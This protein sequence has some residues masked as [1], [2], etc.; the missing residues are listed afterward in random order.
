MEKVI[1]GQFQITKF[2]TDGDHSEIVQPE[3][4]A[5][6]TAVLKKYVDQYGSVSEAIKH[7]DEFAD[8]EW[9]V[10]TTNENGIAVSKELAYGTYIVEQTKGAQDTENVPSFTFTVSQANQDMKYYHINNKPL[11]TY[12]KIVKKDAESGKTV[13]LAG[14]TFK[15]KDAD[16][17]Y[18]TQKLGMIKVDTFVTN[19]DGI[20]MTPLKLD[21]GD[22]TLEE[23]TAPNGYV[24]NKEEIPFTITTNN[25]AET[26]EDG[27]PITVV[28]C[29][30]QAVKGT[31]SI[32]KLVVGK[33][34]IVR[35][36]E[37]P[38]GYAVADD[39]TFTV[40][41]TG[42]VQTVMMYDKEIVHTGAQIGS[43]APFG[44]A[45]LISLAAL[46]FVISKR[47]KEAE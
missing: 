42:K 1:T 46:T 12:V 3:K 16:G 29:N 45:M 41:D 2:I 7:K 30:D 11:E 38:K 9:D 44:G 10:L 39:I 6:F 23:I 34:Y 25:I 43:V 33:E 19:A 26:D 5:E 21:A 24:L 14:A 13:A 22:Y 8:A 32:E 20:V 15:I 17:N 47:R 31:I 18:V 36:K 37:A 27:D 35:E 4:D 40:A 28:E